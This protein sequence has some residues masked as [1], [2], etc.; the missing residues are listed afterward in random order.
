M[1][2][3][4]SDSTLYFNGLI[5]LKNINAKLIVKKLSNLSNKVTQI[6]VSEIQEL[7]TSGAYIILKTL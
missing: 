5:T 6:D 3:K 2:L 7:D 1:N 4:I